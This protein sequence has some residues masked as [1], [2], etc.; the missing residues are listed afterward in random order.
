MPSIENPNL[1]FGALI[2]FFIAMYFILYLKNEKK[3][4]NEIGKS[5]KVLVDKARLEERLKILEDMHKE[6]RGQLKTIVEF[7]E[8]TKSLVNK[9]NLLISDRL[10]PNEELTKLRAQIKTRNEKLIEVKEYL[11]SEREELGIIQKKSTIDKLINNTIKKIEKIDSLRE[12]DH[13]LIE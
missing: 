5:N 9:L 8:S 3:R 10:D 13:L 7:N 11:K 1:I 4:D 2:L 6:T 12:D